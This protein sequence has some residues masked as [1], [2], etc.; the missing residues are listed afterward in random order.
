M[1]NCLKSKWFVHVLG[2]YSDMLPG[3][4]LK[5]LKYQ[6][7]R[8]GLS[9]NLSSTKIKYSSN[10]CSVHKKYISLFWVLFPERDT[11][12]FVRFLVLLSQTL[13]CASHF[14][15]KKLG[16]CF[17]MVEVANRI[18]DVLVSV[19]RS[20][21]AFILVKTIFWKHQLWYKF[22]A[23]VVTPFVRV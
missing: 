4:P 2:H 18:G 20:C 3:K 8:K 19:D 13:F 16:K 10:H 9:P 11:H 14:G 1:E 6:A 12:C 5:N 15:I 17:E 21:R 23:L 7:L 22:I